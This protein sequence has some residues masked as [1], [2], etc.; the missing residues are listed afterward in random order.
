MHSA[1]VQL[2]ICIHRELYGTFCCSMLHVQHPDK[3]N[4]IIKLKKAKFKRPELSSVSLKW[5]ATKGQ[6]KCYLNSLGVLSDSWNLPKL[7]RDS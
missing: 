1:F 7:Y 6:P 5:E 3:L 4:V 2:Y